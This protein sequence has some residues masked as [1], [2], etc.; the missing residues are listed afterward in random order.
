[1][2]TSIFDRNKAV[3]Q[4]YGKKKKKVVV[5]KHLKPKL[6]TD[7]VYKASGQAP[8]PC[9]DYCEISV[10]KDHVTWRKWRI[11]YIKTPG[12]SPT[13]TVYNIEDFLD[14]DVIEVEVE[15]SLGSDVYNMAVGYITKS[16]LARLPLKIL[17]NITSS[18]NVKDISNMQLVNT[19]FRKRLHNN[20]IW[21]QLLKRDFNIDI[22]KLPL[23]QQRGL[24]KQYRKQLA[25]EKEKEIDW[26]NV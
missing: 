11:R 19:V 14:S 9:K 16:W 5:A 23:E 21:K 22:K 26:D 17:V 25:K 4:I 8:A 1:M 6:S 3:S 12:V 10:F 13:E 7:V 20:S 15:Q 24:K 2:S 18:L